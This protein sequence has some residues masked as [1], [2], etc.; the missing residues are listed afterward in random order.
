MINLTPLR[1]FLGKVK[2]GIYQPETQNKQP[3]PTVDSIKRE[4]KFLSP[5]ELEQGRMGLSWDVVNYCQQ[6]LRQQ[7][8]ES[9][10]YWLT[11]QDKEH[12]EL[13]FQPFL[14]YRDG[15]VWRW[16][17]WG[18]E[19]Y[20]NNQ[21]SLR[22]DKQLSQRIATLIYDELQGHDYQ[23]GEIT[24]WPA[25]GTKWNKFTATIRHSVKA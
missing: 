8:L 1:R 9:K 15:P 3:S 12:Q 6:A 25:Y 22:Q 13:L 7:Q 24:S 17:E 14:L 16:L 19:N 2:Y 21:Y 18:L 10:A 11:V 23:Y 4:W 20:R 5:D